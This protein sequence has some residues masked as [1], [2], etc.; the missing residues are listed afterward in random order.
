MNEGHR[1]LSEGSNVMGGDP[2]LGSSS[3]DNSRFDSTKYDDASGVPKPSPTHQPGYPSCRN[4][5]L[6]NP[7]TS[8]LAEV[9]AINENAIRN[10][11]SSQGATELTD[12]S[13][14]SDNRTEQINSTGMSH[15]KMGEPSRIDNDLER[16]RGIIK[17]STDNPGVQRSESN[18]DDQTRQNDSRGGHDCECHEWV[19]T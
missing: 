4:D 18:V 8:R 13:N 2:S 7:P 19:S 12:M 14:Q 6:S 9:T 16:S 17:H 5:T 1:H 11:S 3:N 10:A 15:Y